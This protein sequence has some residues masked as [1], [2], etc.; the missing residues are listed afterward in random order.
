[1]R[2]TEIS[3]YRRGLQT[4]WGIGENSRYFGYRRGLQTFGCIPEGNASVGKHE[5]RAQK[6]VS[7]AE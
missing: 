5:L 1:M 7:S 6:A 2:N 4:F 3:G